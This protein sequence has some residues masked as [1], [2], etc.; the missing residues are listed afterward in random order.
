MQAVNAGGSGITA[1]AAPPTLAE[2]ETAATPIQWLKVPLVIGLP[3]TV[4]TALPGMPPHEESAM[5]AN[6]TAQ[7]AGITRAGLRTT[8]AL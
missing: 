6:K 3:S 7:S 4:R 1:D 5:R 2:D 8:R